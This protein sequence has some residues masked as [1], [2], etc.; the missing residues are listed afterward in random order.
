MNGFLKIQIIKY[1]CYSGNE[2]TLEKLLIRN[3][4]ENYSKKEFDRLGLSYIPQM[5]KM[6][7][8]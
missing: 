5:G 3:A 7:T 2:L 6:E 1:R 8:L 4:L